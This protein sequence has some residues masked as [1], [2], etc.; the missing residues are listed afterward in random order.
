MRTC[1][2]GRV[3]LFVLFL[4]AVPVAAQTETAD[5]PDLE[6]AEQLL[7]EDRAQE[8]FDLL[9]PYEFDY[10]GN[11]KYD[12]LLGVAALASGQ[13]ERSTLIFER[14]LALDP[15]YLGV[16]LDLARSYFQ[17][18]DLARAS[19]EF[20]AVLAEEPPAD[21]RR[22][23]ERYL[24]AI[25]EEQHPGR[26]SVNAYVEVSGGYDSNVNSSTSTNVINIPADGNR[27][28]FLDA[29]EVAQED[30]YAS[31]A[32]GAEAIFDL[33]S[34][35]FGYVGGDLRYRGYFDLTD[36]NYGSTDGY[37]GLGTHQGR[38]FLR[39]GANGGRFFF[40]DA[41]YRKDHGYN[42][43]WRYQFGDND[44]IT[45]NA[46]FDAYR[47]LQF[48]DG[49][50]DFDQYLLGMGWLH[51]L[52]SGNSLFSINV[53]GGRDLAVGGRPDGDADILGARLYYQT[54]TG[55]GVAIFT[56]AGTQRSDYETASDVF[57]SYRSERIYDVAVGANWEFAPQWSLRPQL[58]YIKNDSN[59]SLYSFTRV[60]AALNL[61]H[62]FRWR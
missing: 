45:L 21:L 62:E 30:F 11:V 39:F 27:P 31:T 20:Q 24:L 36:S 59:V 19:R 35:W 55:G 61:R 25:E 14:V 6:L 8:A 26:L 50:Y 44:Q 56:S 1:H 10:A 15:G 33:S 58:T 48:L 54:A 38:H 4:A 60:D 40:D 41:A 29:S 16:R 47:Y 52:A 53:Y 43:D 22:R 34:R 17:L 13:P 28:I 12:Y 2:L 51:I 42:V 57:L 37:I 9:E 46:R 49:T 23:A 5:E 7:R 3:V 32:I 18:G